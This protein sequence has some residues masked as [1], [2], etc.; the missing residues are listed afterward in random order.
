MLSAYFVPNHFLELAHSAKVARSGESLTSGYLNPGTLLFKF[1]KSTHRY[2]LGHKPT[3]SPY[4]V[5]YPGALCYPWLLSYDKDRVKYSFL[6]Y[7][8]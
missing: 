8:T 2:S 4:L 1:S 3:L 6:P 7:T 5:V